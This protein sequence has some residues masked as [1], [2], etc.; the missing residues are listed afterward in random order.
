LG[1][2]SKEEAIHCSG[3]AYISNECIAQDAD[4]ICDVY[5]CHLQI[6]CSLRYEGISAIMMF[7][8]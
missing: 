6:C 1:T 2:I 5:I 7:L 3:N 8:S 4:H